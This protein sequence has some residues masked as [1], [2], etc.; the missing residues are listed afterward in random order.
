MKS[1]INQHLF[2]FDSQNR[3]SVRILN[4]DKSTENDSLVDKNVISELIGEILFQ[5]TA[6]PLKTIPKPKL[7]FTRECSHSENKILLT[8]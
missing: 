8:F 3:P 1:I 4:E 7:D 2:S 5:L 6:I